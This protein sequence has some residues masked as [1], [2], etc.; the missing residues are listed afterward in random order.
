MPIAIEFD[1]VA[2]PVGR[3]ELATKYGMANDP[4]TL[5]L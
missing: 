5:K 1:P 2:D 3:L 4:V